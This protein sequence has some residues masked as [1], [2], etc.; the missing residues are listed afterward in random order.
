[1][2]EPAVLARA[3]LKHGLVFVNTDHGFNLGHDPAVSSPQEGIFVARGHED[4]HDLELYERLGRPPTFRYEYSTSGALAP[5]LLS[6]VPRRTSRYEAE[7]EWP[8]ISLTGRAYPIHFPCASDGRGL[9][10]V[11]GGPVS[12]PLTGAAGDGP[13]EIGWIATHPGDIEVRLSLGGGPHLQLSAL[14][15]GCG[16]WRMEG[17]LPPGPTLLHVRLAQGEVA[18]DFLSR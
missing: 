15:P 14:G 16:V 5:R 12:F 13:L 10:L 17:R 6:H 9:R 7:A 8:A 18:L 11:R 2:F 4:A 1:M 3:G